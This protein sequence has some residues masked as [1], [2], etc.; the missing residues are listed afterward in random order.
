MKDGRMLETVPLGQVNRSVL[1]EK[2]VGR[3]IIEFFP[4]HATADLKTPSFSIINFQTTAMKHAVSF[5]VRAGEIF[6]I[7]GLEGCGATEIARGIFGV[8]RRLGGKV[9]LDKRPVDNRSPR[10]ALMSGLG[11]VTKDRRKEG[12]ILTS[13]VLE[14]MLIPLRINQ[15]R[16]GFIHMRQERRAADLMIEK[17]GIKAA[18]LLMDV[19]SMSG[20]NQQKVILAKWLLTRCRTL[21]VDEPTRGVDVESKV[22]IY[23]LLRELVEQGVIVIVV[24]SDMEEVLGLCDRILVLHR[25]KIEA[26][27]TWNKASEKA[28][29]LAATGCALDS[30]GRP[31]ESTA[32][33]CG[34]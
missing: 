26:N 21:I 11:F 20:G 6:G 8:D 12:L 15:K 5:E 16:Y 28:V 4:R 2:M 1:V 22:E 29:M 31:L 24:S 10:S 23:K 33:G 9:L 19:E 18:N 3:S 7:T 34:G 25:G 13:S 32:T 30:N 27:L 14:N 17:L